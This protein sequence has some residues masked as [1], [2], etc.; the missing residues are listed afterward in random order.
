M[1]V[2]EGTMANK[3]LTNLQRVRERIEQ[4]YQEV[5]TGA[6]VSRPGDDPLS[7]Q[8]ILD[9]N[10]LLEDG[11]QF[12][13]NIS[14]GT[15][16]LSSMESALSCMGDALIRVKELAMGAANGTNSAEQR[17]SIEI[18]VKQLKEQL[19]SLGNSQI[20]GRYVFSGYRNDTPPFD[21]NGAYAGGSGDLRIQID[22]TNTVSVNYAGDKIL[23]GAGG[24]TDII[25]TLD[26][27][28]TSLENDDTAGIQGTLSNIDQSMNQILSA[29]ADI[30][31]RTNRLETASSFIDDT[32][33]YL[34]KVIS[35]K[36]DVDFVQAVSDMTRQQTAFEAALAATSKISKM[37]LVDYL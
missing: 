30:G 26:T 37:S 25:A 14:S 31:A 33:V 29:R 5:S 12:A 6:K 22:R 32:R 2:T 4:L 10:G 18:E 21:A 20:N 23:K 35:S 3:S 17:A 7:A 16:Y 28:I 1:R 9:L 8:Q 19:I 11:E 34:K 24:G 13:K 36:Q 27:L 15:T